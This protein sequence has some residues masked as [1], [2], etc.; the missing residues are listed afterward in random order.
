MLVDKPLDFENS[1]SPTNEVS[2]WRGSEFL[3]D[4]SQSYVF[5][6]ASVFSERKTHE[7]PELCFELIFNFRFS[8]T[9]QAKWRTSL[10]KS[11]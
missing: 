2:A 10:L 8:L 9:T 3:I 11:S 6:V 1:R 7:C 5:P 4:T